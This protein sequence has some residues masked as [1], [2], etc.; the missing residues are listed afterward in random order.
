MLPQDAWGCLQDCGEWLPLWL[1]LWRFD[2]PAAA[3]SMPGLRC[4]VMI[5]RPSWPLRS[6]TLAQELPFF[7]R[8]FRLTSEGSL[9]RSQLRPP[10]SPGQSTC[11]SSSRSSGFSSREPPV[12]DPGLE[13]D[14]QSGQHLL[15]LRRPSR[16]GSNA[17]P[18]DQLPGDHV[19]LNCRT[20][21]CACTG[22]GT[23][24]A[25]CR[26]C[27]A[28]VSRARG[29]CDVN[30]RGRGGRGKTGTLASCG[31]VGTTGH[32]FAGR[33]RTAGVSPSLPLGRRARR[34]FDVVRRGPSGRWDLH[35]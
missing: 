28:V 24:V 19:A 7:R 25:A 34:G 30:E 18:L 26:A 4:W 15:R 8:W 12:H 11:R 20:A 31:S 9:V 3:Q 35:A 10:R 1:P 2:H 13:Q 5:R 14:A 21:I 27:R 29:P 22:P 16:L 17:V 32:G 33:A 23:A 6:I